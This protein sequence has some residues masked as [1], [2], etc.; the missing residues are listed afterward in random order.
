MKLDFNVLWFDDQK[1]YVSAAEEELQE[2]LSEK[3][4]QLQVNW[5]TGDVNFN[6]LVEKE[7]FNN[8]DLIL[9]D[10]QMGE[11]S[12]HGDELAGIIRESFYTDIIFYSGED[13]QKLKELIAQKPVDG[14]YCANR[15]NLADAIVKVVETT[16]RIFQHPNALRGMVMAET[17]D[18]D[19]IIT[20]CLL[21]YASKLPPEEITNYLTAIHQWV[22]EKSQEN[23][24][25]FGKKIDQ[26]PTEFLSHRAFQATH[27][28]I[29]LIKSI[30]SIDSIKPFIDEL[31]AYQAEV[32]GPRNELAHVKL[33]EKNGS[34]TLVGSEFEFTHESLIALRKTLL[35]HGKNFEKIKAQLG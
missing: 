7:A 18:F 8:Y 17:A 15:K 9:V 30:E 1:T 21:T 20:N 23:I 14:V 33:E 3:G 6:D 10:Y 27:R 2:Y 12:R 29:H 16:I 32:I 22:D 11:K 35:K 28:L 4:F 31:K 34:L 24:K 26:N 5:Q 13:K 19:D 25:Q